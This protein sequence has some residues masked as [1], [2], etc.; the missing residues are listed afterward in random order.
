MIRANH[1]FALKGT[2][3]MELNP[4]TAAGNAIRSTRAAE[5]C[6]IGRHLMTGRGDTLLSLRHAEASRATDA[7]QAVLK[8]A[9]TSGT[10]VGG[11]GADLVQY[12]QLV[13]AFFESLRSASAFDFMMPFMRTVP[14]HSRVVS[15]TTGAVGSLHPEGQIKP[16][17]SLALHGDQVDEFTTTAI[18]IL[19]DE[20]MKIGGPEAVAFFNSE[21]RS[22]VAA[23]TD[24]QFVQVLT[25]GISATATNG[26]T[27]PAILADLAT[28]AGAI[29]TSKRSK[30]F[31]LVEPST[32]RAWAFKTT[33]QGELLFSGMTPTGGVISGVEVLACDGMTAGTLV[34]VDSS[35]I[36]ANAGTIELSASSVADIVM[37]TSPSSPP[38]ASAIP[39]SL[40][41]TNRTALKALRLFGCERLRDG[42]VA[43][44]SGVNYSGNSPA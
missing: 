24:T 42:A 18:M 39:Q 14:R 22:A 19:N 5:F 43:I 26:A 1:C 28:L 17:S 4:I 27:S 3:E 11:W 9:V 35:Q 16:V 29:T 7:I 30:L 23:A 15:V 8:T 34:M 20:V 2:A 41:G 25:T 21:L 13:A 44:I 31:L 37:D 38:S 40:Y 10:A 32:A 33:P 6:A 12:D 36:A